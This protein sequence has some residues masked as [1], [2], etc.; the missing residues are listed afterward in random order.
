MKKQIEE[1]LNELL[2]LY[3]E[4][5]VLDAARYSLFG[6]GKRVRPLLL[7][8]LLKDYGIDPNLGL[9]SAIALELIQTYSL[10]HD[11]LPAMDND[12]FRRGQLSNHKVFGE[13]FAILAGDA[14]LTMAFDVLANSNYPAQDIV[15]LTKCLTSHSGINGMILGQALDISYENTPVDDLESLLKMY[16]L[17]TG[18]LIACALESAA[19]IAHKQADRPLLKEIGLKC[20]RAFQIQDDILDQT[21]TTQEIG[22]TS[23]SDMANHKCTVLSFLSLEQA[24]QLVSKYYQ[25][26]RESLIKLNLNHSEVFSM[27]EY[28]MARQR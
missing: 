13:D 19:I 6:Q 12:D 21:K 16:E 14:L 17:K 1:A 10:I 24:N 9:E 27:I 15:D 8:G 25:E 20:G 23:K 5:K 4:S 2:A 7:V 28:L 11:D 3:K 22:K 18:G 26:I